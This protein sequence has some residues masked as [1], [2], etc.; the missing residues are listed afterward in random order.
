MAKNWAIAIGI[1]EY[2][3]LARPLQYAQRDAKLMRDWLQNRARFEKVYYYADNS[4]KIGN[5]STRPTRSNLLR[6]LDVR[7]QQ[8][9]M[10]AGD[11]FWFFFS[12][13]GVRH[14]GQDYLM[15]ADSY[16]ENIPGSAI[17]VSYVLGQLRRCGADNIVL[18]LDACRN[19]GGRSME[20][21][22]RQTAQQA[23]KTGAIVISSCSPN[24]FSYEVEAL[25]QGVFT[26]ALFEGLGVQG[27]CATVEQL[28][29]Y[30]ARRVPKLNREYGKPP[31]IPWTKVE[32]LDRAHLILVPK[33]ATPDDVKILKF[34]ACQAELNGD[35]TLARQLWVRVNTATLGND[36][37]A[38]KAI[39]RLASGVTRRQVMQW[40]LWG[41]AGLGLA[42]VG[43]AVF[44]T[45]KSDSPIS[46]PSELAF[47]R[48]SFDVITVNEKGE[49]IDHRPGE[50]EFLAENINGVAPKMVAI[51]GG[52]FLMGSPPGKGSAFVYPQHPVTVPSFLRGKYPVT[53]AQW[54]AV[55]SLPKI[56]R[57]LKPEPSS[58]KGKNR[59]VEN[60]SWYDAVEFCQRFSIATGRDYRLPSEAEWEY[61]CRAGTTTPFHFG[62]T[63]TS[64][65]ANYDGRYTYAS[66]LRGK[67]RGHTTDVGS[68]P[69][70]AFGLYDM[71]GNIWEWCA[72]DWHE[73]YENAPKDGR[74]WVS[75]V[76]RSPK[77]IRGGVWYIDPA[78]CCSAYR[79]EVSPDLDVGTMMG[80]R[81]VCAVP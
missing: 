60:V 25:K 27:R 64:Q 21:M 48:F 43:N 74:A 66:E 22:G 68:F 28:D 5:T 7:F 39:E 50:A 18:L 37:D 80:F 63:I 15:A 47:D 58:F 3:H 12:G 1:N 23:K 13:H 31:Q 36:S 72:D 79:S 26:Y 16:P 19:N 38:V 44:Q 78:F 73:N 59:P 30:L 70:N 57:D 67:N 4:P 42:V 56:D 76:R 81:L 10:G 75:N 34:D 69:P 65:L 6:L 8:P 77:V 29:A 52:E 54:Q 62:E 33:N 2:E 53:Q 45:K 17:P 61:A 9:F 55:V 40:S 49:E 46:N 20:G 41:G 24:E 51:P 71:H 32:P 11:N 35:R 14:E